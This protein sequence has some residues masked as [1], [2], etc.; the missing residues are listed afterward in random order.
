M[1][2]RFDDHPSFHRAAAGMVGGALLFGL[3]LHP[4]TPLAPL[5]G[6]FLG[7]AAGAAVAHGK[8]AWR[9]ATAGI[10]GAGLV[11]APPSW[12]LL[13]AAGSVLALG[14]AIGGP[15]GLRGLLGF[16]L[17]V[18]TALVATWCALRITTARETSAWPAWLAAG[19]AAASMGLVGVLAMLPRHLTIALDPIQAARRR[20][21]ATLDPEVKSL[22]ERSVA[23]WAMTRGKLAPTDPGARL[24]RDGVLKTLEVAAKSAEVTVAG[25]SDGELAIRMAE[26]DKRISA[27][28]DAEV[29]AQYQAARAALD[30]QQRYRDHIRQGGERLVAR[31]HNHVTTL[32][33]FQLAATGLA[34]ARVANAGATR[35]LDELSQDVAASGEALAELELGVPATPAP[36]SAEVASAAVA[37]AEVAK[38]D[39]ASA[40]VAA[41]GPV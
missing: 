31:M 17:A 41:A 33:K 30:D 36:T 34:A 40:E 3:A 28:T 39:D 37:S 12:A 15:R 35:Q 11:V 14:L 29:K 2:I 6:G 21:P 25:A 9:M 19:T 4:V 27:A 20:L 18:A 1:D 13:A 23:I 38:G 22:C 26:L 10:A 8:A 24:V 5:A 7:I 32:E 16:G